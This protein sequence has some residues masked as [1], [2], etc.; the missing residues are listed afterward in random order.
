MIRVSG[1][2]ETKTKDNIVSLESQKARR[3]TETEK[4]LE[5]IITENLPNLEEAK[6]C[7]FRKLSKPQTN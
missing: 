7:R 1:T 2:S 4:G 5:E 6:T 3:N